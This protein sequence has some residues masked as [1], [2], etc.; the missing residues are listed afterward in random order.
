MRLAHEVNDVAA[1]V[2]ADLAFH[3]LILR[4]SE[5]VLWLSSLNPLHRVLENGGR[6]SRCRD[7]QEHA[8]GDHQHIAEALESRDR[9]GPRSHGFPHAADFGRSQNLVLDG[10]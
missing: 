4:A 5:N 2:E 8:I 10:T 3:D 7:I 9:E 6:N 1:F